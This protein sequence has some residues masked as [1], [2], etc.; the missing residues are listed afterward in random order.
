M[1]QCTLCSRS[2]SPRWYRLDKYT[3]GSGHICN[4]CYHKRQHKKK[5]NDPKELAYRKEYNRRPEVIIR[6]NKWFKE[7]LEN[8]KHRMY[9]A[10]H[11]AKQRKLS[12]ELSVEQYTEL[13]NKLCFYCN[14][15]LELYGTGLDRIN[16]SLGYT[17][18]NVVSCCRI[19]N[20]MKNDL[21][22]D[23]FY[24]QIEKIS[25]QERKVF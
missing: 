20:V 9:Q 16:S 19:C 15:T 25:H 2:E 1:K 18:S 6:R 24:L 23:A 14:S 13:I 21:T 4:I 8:P 11:K 7:R 3:N 10:S 12:W 5:R 22:Q 17:L